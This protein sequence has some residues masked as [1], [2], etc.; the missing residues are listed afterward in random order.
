MAK[1][2]VQSGTLRTIVQAESTQKAAVW[3]VH[4]VLGQV[5]NLESAPSCTINADAATA[6]D[7]TEYSQRVAVLGSTVC[8]SEQ[9]FD[10]RDA[11]SLE[12]LSVVSQWN[13]LVLT[14]DRLEKM[15]YRVAA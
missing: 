10:R 3:A 6:H 7:M 12:T 4:Q 15:L 1:Y 8:V 9:G 14:L 11:K 5:M 13:E 2:Y